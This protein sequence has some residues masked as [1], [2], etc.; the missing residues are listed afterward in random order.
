VIACILRRFVTI[1]DLFCTFLESAD[2]APLTDKSGR[3]Y[4][5]RELLI[6][7]HFLNSFRS[8]VDIDELYMHRGIPTGRMQSCDSIELTKEIQFSILTHWT[9]YI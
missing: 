8:S 1:D 6:S 2:T 4:L 7:K 3:S 5:L 9:E